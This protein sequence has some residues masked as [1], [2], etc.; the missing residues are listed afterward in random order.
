VQAL[1]APTTTFL[2]TATYGLA[3]IAVAETVIEAERARLEGRFDPLTVDGAIAASRQRFGQL[4]GVPADRVAVAGQVSQ[5]VGLVA[6]ALPPGSTVLAPEGDFTSVLWPFL[7]RQADGVRVR[8]VPLDRLVE[9][10]DGHVDLVAT[11]IVQSADG[12]VLDPEVLIRTAH[13]HRAR[14]L[15]DVTQ[16]AGWLPLDRAGDADWVVCGGYKWLMAPRGTAFLSGTHEALDLLRPLA[17]GWYAGDDPWASCYGGPL[18]LAADARRFDV[19]PA[20]PAWLGQRAALDVLAEVGIDRIHAHDVGLANRLRAG[21]GLAPGS[22]AIVSVEAP[23]GTADVLAAA[24]VVASVR[25]GR[26][27]L[28]CHL[29]NDAADVDRA[30]DV[31]SGVDGMDAGRSRTDRPLVRV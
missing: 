13:A 30:L 25:A 15:L 4:V 6:A 20:W 19:S 27:R 12:R 5:S 11:S 23:E 28:S 26:L 9:S 29:H 21:L 3:P 16:A 2:N 24:G 22:S 14:V 17:A 8:L 1:F 7:A 31:L 18:R 10:I